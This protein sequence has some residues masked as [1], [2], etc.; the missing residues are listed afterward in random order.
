MAGGSAIEPREMGAASSNN[1]IVATA[2]PDAT[3]VG[4]RILASGGSAAN[5]AVA[6]QMVL[7]VVEPQSLGLGSG[8]ILLHRIAEDVQEAAI[9]GFPEPFPRTSRQARWVPS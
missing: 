7:G 3:N 2:N 6:I 4:T 5:A 8:A 1:K 9:S